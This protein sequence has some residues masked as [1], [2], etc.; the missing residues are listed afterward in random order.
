M[1]Q[2]QPSNNIFLL[3]NHCQAIGI[4]DQV[5]QVHVV[6]HMAVTALGLT[7]RTTGILEDSDMAITSIQY[8]CGDAA[9]FPALFFS[10]AVIDLC[11]ST[12][13]IEKYCLDPPAH[14]N[15]HVCC[16]QVN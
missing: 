10:Y 12:C 9:C 5:Q 3:I 16:R 8:M 14:Q 4:T 13:P 6:L 1:Q 11:H 2:H 15:E 7:G